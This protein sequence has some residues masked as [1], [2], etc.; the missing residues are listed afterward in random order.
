MLS[1]V[2]L[3]D[4]V[5]STCL[6]ACVRVCVCACVRVCVCACV[7]VCMCTFV[8]ARAC[9]RAHVCVCVRACVCVCQFCTLQTQR[10]PLFKENYRCV[11]APLLRACIILCYRF[12]GCSSANSRHSTTTAVSIGE[13][14]C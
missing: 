6:C 8:C 2:I 14:N 7:R 1:F 4:F 3:N 10:K 13:H 11:A 9:V 12:Y 5:V